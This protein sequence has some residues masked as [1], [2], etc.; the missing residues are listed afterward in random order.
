MS[1]NLGFGQSLEEYELHAKEAFENGDYKLALKKIEKGLQLDSRNSDL[2]DLKA[3]V[4]IRL[5][6]Y[7]DAYDTYTA[8]IAIATDKANLYNHRAYL[9]EGLQQFDEAIEDY[10]KAIDHTKNDSIKN[11][12]ISNRAAAK[13]GKRDFQGAY[14]DLIEAYEF[15]STDIS[16]LNNLAMTCDETG[17]GAETLK[18]LIKASEIDSLFAPTYINI[19]FKYQNMGEHNKAIEYFNK[20]LTVQPEEP[21]VFSNRSYSKLKTGDLKGAMEDIEKSI[22]LY[23]GNSY[24]YRNRALI[25]IEQGKIAKA[26]KDLQVA[27]DKGFTTMYG[28]EVE[29]L[30][31]EHCK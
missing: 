28:D 27:I 19:G 13:S 29:N 17:R 11:K 18:Y 16:I 24:A 6:K 26:C 25:Y 21:L 23:P 22:K 12:F 1:I 30:Q 10:S 20:A 5:G 8:A 9:L 31:K 14:K 3:G 2:L 15:D 7:Q 4:Y